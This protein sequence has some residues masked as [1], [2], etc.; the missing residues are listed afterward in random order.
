MRWSVGIEVEGD[1]V[2]SREEVVELADA[3]AATDG[4]ATGIGSNRYGAQLVV[5][6]V[7]REEAIEKATEEFWR[8]VRKAGLRPAP[9]VRSEAVSEDEDAAG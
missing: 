9:I 2:L 5:E 3:V 1:R 8:A 6:A 4:I 7:S